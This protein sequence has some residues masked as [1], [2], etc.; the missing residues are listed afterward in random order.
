MCGGA[1]KPPL[2]KKI[3]KN[4]EIDLINS[5]QKSETNFISFIPLYLYLVFKDR[6]KSKTLRQN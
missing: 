4:I 2:L 6:W 3:K 1:H 5:F